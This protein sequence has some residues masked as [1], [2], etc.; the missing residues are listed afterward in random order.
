MSKLNLAFDQA[1]NKAA[2]GDFQ[3]VKVLLY[4]FASRVNVAGACVNAPG[5]RRLA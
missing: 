5:P 2:S 3:A 4:W 1:M